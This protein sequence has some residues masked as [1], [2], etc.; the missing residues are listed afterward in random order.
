MERIII[1]K[2]EFR[3]ATF[4]EALEFLKK[5]SVELDPNSRPIGGR[6]VIVRL[7]PVVQSQGAALA[8]PT[9]AAAPSP[10]PPGVPGL[11]TPAAVTETSP[12]LRPDPDA[13]GPQEARITLSLTNISLYEALRYI[14]SQA[15]LKLRILT[16]A[17]EIVPVS[18]PDPMHTREKKRKEVS[19]L[20]IAK[21][22]LRDVT[23]DEA[24]EV[25]HRE[26]RRLDPRHRG[27]SIVV[28]P[29]PP[30]T[31]QEAEEIRKITAGTGPF[32]LSASLETVPLTSALRLVASLSNHSYRIQ[33]DG[34]HLGQICTVDRDS[35]T[36]ATRTFRIPPHYVPF[37]QKRDARHPDKYIAELKR[38][39]VAF[40]ERLGVDF[41]E[42]TS[43]TVNTDATRLTVHQSV[44]YLNFIKDFLT[45]EPPPKVIPIPGPKV[46]KVTENG[47]PVT[48]ENRRSGSATGF[49]TREYLIPPTREI[50]PLVGEREL[51]V[52]PTQ[53]VKGPTAV[54]L[55]EQRKLVV[56]HTRAAHALIRQQ[57]EAG[58]RAY[59]LHLEPPQFVLPPI[60]EPISKPE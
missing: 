39:C 49:V 26:S 21:L 48:T 40:F 30:M 3:E 22:E 10:P 20:V 7:P 1:P 43:A 13:V 51:P 35:A 16:D 19:H 52:I 46:P 36:M 11:D 9:E 44:V 29:D 12:P 31:P 38:D 47:R 5:R 54:Y 37:G 32:T 4:R 42:G 25:L 45:D 58:W 28:D 56:R 53:P 15:G 6:G 41:P 59:Y 14:T 34:V 8:I 50:P 27:V 33:A 57:I 60:P 55:P 24:I 23:L 18:D 17:I 2:L